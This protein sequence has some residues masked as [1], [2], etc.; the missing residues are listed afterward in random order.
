MPASCTLLPCPAKLSAA[1]SLTHAEA[2]G[3]MSDPKGLAEL[4]IE[5]AESIDFGTVSFTVKRSAMA[6]PK[7]STSPSSPSAV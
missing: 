4:I 3:D 6:Y 7:P 5:A 1:V 2:V